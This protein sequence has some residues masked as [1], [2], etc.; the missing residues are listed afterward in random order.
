MSG[1]GYAKGGEI[2]TPQ[3][4]FAGMEEITSV[5]G[6][7][8][9]LMSALA[10]QMTGKKQSGVKNLRL[11]KM[12]GSVNYAEGGLAAAEEVRGMGRGDDEILLHVS[13]EEYEALTGMWGEPDINPN[14]GMPEYG[15]L[16]KLWKKVKGVVKK[17][18]KSPIFQFIAPI[19]LNAF[20]PGAGSALG[21]ALGLGGKAA[22]VVGNTL[23]R[24][25]I[26]AAGGGKEGALSGAISGLTGGGAGLSL[27]K[28][29][30]LTGRAAEMA[31]NALIGGAGGTIGGGG[32]AQGALGNV[33][34]AEAMRALQPL[35]TGIGKGLKN[36]FAPGTGGMSMVT[37]G[38]GEMS[39]VGQ[40][41]IFGGT[42][43]GAIDMSPIPGSGALTQLG[44]PTS[45]NFL[46]R[47]WDW[48]KENPELAL[49]GAGVLGSLRGSGEPDGP[50]AGGGGDFGG[51]IPEYALDRT[52]QTMD[53]NAYYTYGQTGSE[54]P[55]EF[56]FWGNN[57]AGTP[58]APPTSGGGADL[59]QEDLQSMMARLSSMSGGFAEGGHSKGGG[60]GRDDT[61]EAL[62]S[63]GEYVMDA[64]TVSLLGDGSNDHGAARLDE[65]REA[66]RKHK[67]KGLARG[68]FS[69]DAKR[70]LDYMEGGRAA[71]AGGGKVRQLKKMARKMDRM[72][73]EEVPDKEIREIQAAM[74][75]LQRGSVKRAL[76]AVN[77]GEDAAS[78]FREKKARGGR[79]KNQM[80]ARR[81]RVLA[82]GET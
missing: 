14:T 57:T 61:I 79:V 81:M 63:D 26:G 16:S 72:L 31:G 75:R 77:S 46:T 49:A 64:E 28:T 60:S 19:A 23:I 68:K 40:P 39:P 48:L 76:D 20:I 51:P 25:G 10:E 4:F 34:N 35:E 9:M 30:G 2:R 11:Y 53:P 36:I 78:A 44:T 56:Q 58:T 37:S 21:G 66:L 45:G 54:Q 42:P 3:E 80:L 69:A 6:G 22:T 13:P 17:I 24:S 7:S 70:P 43:G 5:P 15:F 65:M 27:G 82:R 55:G 50:P 38:T 29:L 52:R 33:I 18:V 71:Y 12:G 47:G 41:D 1:L 32:F 62:L 67:G 73:A 74:N 59:S 8:E